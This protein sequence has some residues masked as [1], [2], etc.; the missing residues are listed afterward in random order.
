MNECGR[1]GF[2]TS[3]HL[4]NSI[5]EPWVTICPICYRAE[6]VTITRQ[7]EEKSANNKG[8]TSF[9]EAETNKQ[10]AE[11][12]I[13][14]NAF[15]IKIT[16]RKTE[17]VVE[18]EEEEEML[19]RIGQWWLPRVPIER[20]PGTLDIMGRF[21]GFGGHYYLN[22]EAKNML[23]LA[24]IRSYQGKKREVTA[25]W[26]LENFS[27]NQDIV[28]DPFSGSGMFSL[29]GKV[30]GRKPIAFDILGSAVASTQALIATP[31]KNA[32][33]RV[34]QSIVDAAERVRVDTG[35][36]P[37]SILKW[38]DLDA[39][40]S[41]VRYLEVI[42]GDLVDM[43][44][45]MKNFQTQIALYI[46]Q[47]LSYGRGGY[48]WR[49][50]EKEYRRRS[51]WDKNMD[52][53]YM[54]HIRKVTR[55]PEPAQYNTNFETYQ[56]SILEETP[57][58]DGSVDRIVTDPPYGDMINY[59]AQVWVE[60]WYLGWKDIVTKDEL[61]G[62]SA[63]PKKALDFAHKHMIQDVKT[64]FHRMETAMKEMYRVLRSDGTATFII[65]DFKEQSAKTGATAVINPFRPLEKIARRIGFE[66]VYCINKPFERQSTYKHTH[67]GEQKYERIIIFRKGVRGDDKIIDRIIEKQ[68]VGLE[69]F[70]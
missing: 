16:E 19:S 39:F 8:L 47:R 1:C 24:D 58:E 30:L 67:A 56:Q 63:T 64:F 59:I 23:S 2:P 38:Y 4:K 32:I 52:D 60:E 40:R 9:L 25:R 41:G 20:V 44:Q 46:L 53:E 12:N 55:N 62:V 43:D 3:E 7:K 33:I 31:P 66:E 68:K 22:E 34:G 11:T 48:S 15:K 51:L 42:Q 10:I 35:N 6:Q 36:Y 28:L 13:F 14:K 65:G 26:L 54:R 57:L 49:I 45:R 37:K 69:K 21:K 29:V 17:I 50:D 61:L 27:N 5:L 70:F 18:H